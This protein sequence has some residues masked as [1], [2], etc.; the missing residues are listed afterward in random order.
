MS[1]LT[2][3]INWESAINQVDSGELILGGQTGTVNIAPRQLANRTLYLKDQIEILAGQ[4]AS[5][6]GEGGAGESYPAI[7]VT[8]PAVVGAVT[9]L[10]IGNI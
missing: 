9:V 3:V 4:I 5:L 2:E 10:S 7:E 8:H 1:N 6:G